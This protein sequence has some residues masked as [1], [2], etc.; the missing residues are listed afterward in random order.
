MCRG[1]S[2]VIHFCNSWRS[3]RVPEWLI[4]CCLTSGKLFTL[5]SSVSFRD[6]T[7]RLQGTL[8]E[9]CLLLLQRIQSWMLSETLKIRLNTRLVGFLQPLPLPLPNK[10]IPSFG[11]LTRDMCSPCLSW[12]TS[13]GYFVF[14]GYRTSSKEDI[15][16]DT[17]QNLDNLGMRWCIH[18]ASH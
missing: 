7:L 2:V 4:G 5:C 1:I 11:S 15:S 17:K 3:R 12:N 8:P 6:S 16:T 9:Y 18:S 13:A 10:C 14:V